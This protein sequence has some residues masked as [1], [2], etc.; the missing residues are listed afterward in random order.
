MYLISIFTQCMYITLIRKQN[1][2]RV[3]NAC[4]KSMNIIMFTS[5]FTALEVCVSLCVLIHVNE[6]SISVC[7]FEILCTETPS[8]WC[9]IFFRV[10]LFFVIQT[11]TIFFNEGME[12][13]SLP[14]FNNIFLVEKIQVDK[15]IHSTLSSNKIGFILFIGHTREF[16][17]KKWSYELSYRKYTITNEENFINKINWKFSLWCNSLLQ[18]KKEY[19]TINK[20]FLKWFSPWNLHRN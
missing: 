11:L 6:F 10:S 8:L 7:S 16:E 20:I 15:I 19:Q 5:H 12:E 13:L 18:K 17:V 4:M 3:N 9:I 2:L 14:T 1:A